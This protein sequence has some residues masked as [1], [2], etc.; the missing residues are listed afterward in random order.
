MD[1]KNK[2]QKIKDA[3]SIGMLG[4][5]AVLVVMVVRL[6]VLWTNPVIATEVLNAGA[7]ASENAGDDKPSRNQETAKALKEKNMFM[8]PPSKP[9]PPK[10]VKAILGKEA[11]IGGKWYKVG[12]TVPPGARI[13]SIEATQVKLEW[14]GKEIVLAPIKAAESAKSKKPPKKKEKKKLKPR[15]NNKP[16]AVQEEEEEEEPQESVE[17]DEFAWMGVD[18]P[19]NVREKI[20]EGWNKMTDEQKEQAKEKWN[21]MSDEE[22]QQAVDAMSRQF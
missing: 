22:K 1:G 6:M 19:A 12:D 11:L 17:I 16:Q 14:E 5:V 10:E 8:P 4:I 15:K 20:L 3:L 9:K 7:A 21:K 18:L 2:E 13:L